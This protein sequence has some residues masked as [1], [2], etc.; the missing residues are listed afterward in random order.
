MATLLSVVG[1]YGV[2][3]YMVTR[4][5]RE[6]GIRMALGAVGRQIAAGVLREAGMLVATGLVAGAVAS[7]ALGRFVRSQ[8]YGTTPT[9]GAAMLFGALVLLAVAGAASL[10]PARRAARVTPVV[11]L[12]DE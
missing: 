2:M 11:A 6:I 8:L 3:A 12:R 9:D 7:W 1:L 5:T 4:R 10:L